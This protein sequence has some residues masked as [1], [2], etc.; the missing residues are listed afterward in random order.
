MV[1]L[2][3]IIWNLD[4]Q[5]SEDSILAQWKRVYFDESSFNFKDWDKGEVLIQN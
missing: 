4:K 1:S 3:K 5:A 2:V